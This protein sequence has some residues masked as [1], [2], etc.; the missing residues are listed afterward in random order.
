MRLDIELTANELIRRVSKWKDI[1]LVTRL[2]DAG[3]T[4]YTDRFMSRIRSGKYVI[5]DKRR[6]ALERRY[7]NLIKRQK[8]NL[9]K[10][11]PAAV[12]SAG[13]WMSVSSFLERRYRR[14]RSLNVEF[15]QQ[16]LYDMGLRHVYEKG[17]TLVFASKASL[18]GTKQF[19]AQAIVYEIMVEDSDST[20]SWVQ[21]S[22][23]LYY[24]DP[25][26]KSARDTAKDEVDLFESKNK[27]AAITF[28]PSEYAY[29]W[30]AHDAQN[31][32]YRFLGIGVI[33]L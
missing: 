2:K 29:R 28:N 9:V 18:S 25:L 33:G 30:W 14:D 31:A 22:Q 4:T 26:T 27:Q 7:L 11:S 15:S 19:S 24:G 6:A 3:V 5:P 20:E 12:S 21:A 23:G 17:N 1:T 16:R 10:A 8:R 32:E 13:R